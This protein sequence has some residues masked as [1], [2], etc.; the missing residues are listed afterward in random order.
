MPHKDL[1]FIFNS[2]TEFKMTVK[3]ENS[4]AFKGV[5]HWETKIPLIFWQDIQ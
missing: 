2:Y 3:L 1:V 4:Y 5:M